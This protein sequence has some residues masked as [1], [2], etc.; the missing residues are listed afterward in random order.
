MPQIS[1]RAALTEGPCRGFTSVNQNNL[2]AALASVLPSETID[3][4]KAG[5]AAKTP[6]ESK[7]Q[8][9]EEGE[10]SESERR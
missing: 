9:I 7:A 4:I 6:Q 5:L 3:K 1:G 2:L 10:N 8:T